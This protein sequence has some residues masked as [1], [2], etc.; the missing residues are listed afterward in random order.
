[1]KQN[2]KILRSVIVAFCKESLQRKRVINRDKISIDLFNKI[3]NTQ[4][5]LRKKVY[6]KVINTSYLRCYFI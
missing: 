3:I 2:Q 4:M 5:I 1:M 6:P